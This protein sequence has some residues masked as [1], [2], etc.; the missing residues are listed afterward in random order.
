MS[1]YATLWALRFPRFGAFHID[2]DWVTVL[3]QAVP[4]HVGAEGTDHFASFLPLVAESSAADIRAVVFV[5]Q[6]AEKGTPRSAQ[7]YVGP[8]LVLSGKEYAAVAFRVLHERLCDFGIAG[9]GCLIA[10]DAAG[11][12]KRVALA[13]VGVTQASVRLAAAEQL[14]ADTDLG[15]AALRAADGR[16]RQ[17][18]SAGRRA[19]KR[20]YRKRL[21]G[22]LLD[23]AVRQAAA[24]ARG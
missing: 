21:A 4:G 2:C 8:L 19:R 5:T 1:I 22:V 13:L 3:A 16:D 24:R 7:E 20:R 10:L 6:G 17:A 23:R 12:A 18:R 9:V 11:K 15:D 14:L